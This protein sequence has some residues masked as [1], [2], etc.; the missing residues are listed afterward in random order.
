MAVCWATTP[1]ARYNVTEFWYKI[2]GMID[3]DRLRIS[4]RFGTFHCSTFFFL[5]FSRGSDGQRRLWLG[6]FSERD[7]CHITTNVFPYYHCPNVLIFLVE[8][9]VSGTVVVCEQTITP[10]HKQRG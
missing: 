1:S 4:R 7:G 10:A 6:W 9:H 8:A 5:S 2:S 3:W